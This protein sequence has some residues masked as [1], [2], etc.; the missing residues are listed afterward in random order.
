MKTKEDILEKI[1]EIL[2]DQFE[3]DAALIT[4]DAKLFDDL[5][6]DSIDAVD[7]IVTLQKVTGK[8]VEPEQFKQVRTIRDLVE[9]IHSIIA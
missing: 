8:K 2:S 7:L 1:I 5:D 4:L 9:A 3:V 6:L